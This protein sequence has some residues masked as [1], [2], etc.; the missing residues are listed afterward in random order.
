MHEAREFLRDL[1]NT[2]KH[3]LLMS[4]GEL[5]HD[6]VKKHKSS[7]TNPSVHGLIL[8]GPIP[9]CYNQAGV[10][11]LVVAT[12][13]QKL[14]ADVINYPGI[15]TVDCYPHIRLVQPNAHGQ[16][17]MSIAQYRQVI[18]NRSILGAT[19]II[20]GIISGGKPAKIKCSQ[21]SV[22]ETDLGVMADMAP[23]NYQRTCISYTGDPGMRWKFAKAMHMPCTVLVL[24]S[25]LNLVLLSFTYE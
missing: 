10:K 22:N 7:I 8:D 13:D 12:M 25:A 2:Y 3:V 18:A 16:F 5:W 1:G 17:R 11:H 9:D 24:S 15:K 20:D 19:V 4:G 6:C 23:Q 21:I 14:I